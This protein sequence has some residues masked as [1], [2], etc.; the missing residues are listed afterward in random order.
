MGSLFSKSSESTTPPVAKSPAEAEASS[1]SE[2][3]AEGKETCH[4]TGT[5]EAGPT[6]GKKPE[7]SA[8]NQTTSPE[9]LDQGDLPKEPKIESFIEIACATP[10]PSS[11]AGAQL[12]K[13]SDEAI[14]EPS[15]STTSGEASTETGT[16]S[17]DDLASDLH[18]DRKTTES[19]ELHDPGTTGEM[20]SPADIELPKSFAEVVRETSE[21]VPT[22]CV[23]TSDDLTEDLHPVEG[24]RAEHG[25]T[26]YEEVHSPETTGLMASTSQMI[27]KIEELAAEMTNVVIASGEKEIRTSSSEQKQGGATPD[28]DGSTNQDA[29]EKSA[30]NEMQ[31]GESEESMKISYLEENSEFGT[32][33]KNG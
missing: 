24:M 5:V 15:E 3:A 2:G 31:G 10:I 12:P 19:E 11:P 13:S 29:S 28:S 18:A 1:P 9:P 22:G 33:S 8:A 4:V 16:T 20:P 23:T 32:I 6:D 27:A 30:A 14:P 21:Q 26:E 25:T 17:F 7:D